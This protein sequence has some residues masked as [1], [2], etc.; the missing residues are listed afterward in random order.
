MPD[1]SHSLLCC[2]T[3]YD[4]SATDRS[5]WSLGTDSRRSLVAIHCAPRMT[6]Q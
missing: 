3:L 1:L 2:S 6:E 4:K 5:K